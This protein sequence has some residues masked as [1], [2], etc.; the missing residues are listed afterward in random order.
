MIY[1][2]FIYRCLPFV[3]RVEGFI[4]SRHWVVKAHCRLVAD[5]TD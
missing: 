5:K 1:Y 2:S 4:A 3:L